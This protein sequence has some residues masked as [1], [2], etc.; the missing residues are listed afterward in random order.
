MRAKEDKEKEKIKVIYATALYLVRKETG[1]KKSMRQI[2]LDGGMESSHVQRVL[3]GYVDVSYTTHITIL[4]AIEISLS[5]FS[6][7]YEKVTEKDI[8]E[9]KKYLEDQKL[10]KG[11]K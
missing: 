2:A 3:S 1:F 8:K 11:R 6:L 10:R 5:K 4:E 7:I 9:F